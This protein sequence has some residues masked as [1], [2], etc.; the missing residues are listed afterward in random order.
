MVQMLVVTDLLSQ[1]CVEYGKLDLLWSTAS[2]EI[3]QT[4][5][6]TGKNEK[7]LTDGVLAPSGK[8]IPY[9]L[10]AQSTALMIYYVLFF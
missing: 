4:S 9:V 7:I 2:S 5:R 6:W 3:S 10:L 8:R 1:V